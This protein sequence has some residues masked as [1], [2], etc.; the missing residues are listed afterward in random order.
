MAAVTASTKIDN[1]K[2]ELAGVETGA[3]M[4]VGL[5]GGA[6]VSAAAA[7]AGGEKTN[8]SIWSVPIL[9]DSFL[10]HICIWSRFLGSV[11]VSLMPDAKAC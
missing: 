10:S 1:P 4:F 5:R 7:I 2:I 6:D 9:F 8:A 3:K 11:G